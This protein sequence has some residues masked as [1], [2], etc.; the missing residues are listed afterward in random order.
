MP[1]DSA[2]LAAEGRKTAAPGNES[3]TEGEV[4]KAVFGEDTRI[5][6]GV[7]LLVWLVT[8]GLVV[9]SCFHIERVVRVEVVLIGRCT[10][11]L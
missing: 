6:V 9:R 7:F 3:A 2:F 5:H 10:P 8:L 1:R 11:W 4:G